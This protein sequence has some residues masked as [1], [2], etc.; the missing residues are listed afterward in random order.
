[1]VK[2]YFHRNHCNPKITARCNF[3]MISIVLQVLVWLFEVGIEQEI[4]LVEVLQSITMTW[5]KKAVGAGVRIGIPACSEP[6]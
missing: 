5:R 4:K 6:A 3:V 1:M 2:S